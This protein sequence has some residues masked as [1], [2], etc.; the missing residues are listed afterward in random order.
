MSRQSAAPRPAAFIDRDGVLNHDDGYVGTRE[1]FRWMPGAAAGVRR[2]NEAGFFVFVISNQSG[3]ARGYFGEAEV[4]A[5]HA[6][7]QQELAAQGARID[8]IRFCPHHPDGSVAR[9]RQVC[10]CRKPAAGMIRDLMR[11]WPVD[12]SR[13]L[14]IG[15][16]DS[17][18]AAAKA[19][20]IP[21]Y[22]FT[23]GDFDAFVARLLDDV[24][25]PQGVT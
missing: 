17:D 7:M 4:E 11:A 20:G 12:A 22:R 2:L 24:A 25:R 3:V 23:G 13:S 19:A 16:K 10:N 5:L 8:D 15:D 14:V 18:L 9:Y 21:G 6:W 1:R